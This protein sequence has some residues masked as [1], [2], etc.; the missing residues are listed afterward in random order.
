MG[1]SESVLN[2]CVSDVLGSFDCTLKSKCL[3]NVKCLNL[4]YHC[5]TVEGDILESDDEE[6]LS[7]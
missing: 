2:N 6:T 3:E 4:Y 7:D 5:R 1:L